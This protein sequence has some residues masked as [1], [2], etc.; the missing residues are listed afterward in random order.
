MNVLG[1]ACLS[2]FVL[3]RARVYPGQ[4]EW[5]HWGLDCLG[6]MDGLPP[7]GDGGTATKLER[8]K[9][10]K[11]RLKDKTGAIKEIRKWKENRGSAKKS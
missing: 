11:A 1:G 6:D 5:Q 10:T 2:T 7:L 4:K 3:D 9:W 8:G